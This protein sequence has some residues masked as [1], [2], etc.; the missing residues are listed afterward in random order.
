MNKYVIYRECGRLKVTP[1]SNYRAFIRNARLVQDCSAFGSPAEIIA[2]Y[3][4][5]FGSHETD[6]IVKE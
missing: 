2:Y 4:K 5:W 3:V 6:F 1:E